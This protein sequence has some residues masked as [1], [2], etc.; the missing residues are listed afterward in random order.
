MRSSIP[1]GRVGYLTTCT[2]TS[3]D[4]QRLCVSQVT[5]SANHCRTVSALVMVRQ[6]AAGLVVAIHASDCEQGCHL[7]P[8]QNLFTGCIEIVPLA[9][10][11]AV[12]VPRP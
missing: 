9:R 10:R 2:H 11:P 12:R 8:L 1:Q 3:D 4:L 7:P 6:C 5:R